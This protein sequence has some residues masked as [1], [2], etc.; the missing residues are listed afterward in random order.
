M[1]TTKIH[2]GSMPTHSLRRRIE[3]RIEAT[4]RAGRV[5]QIIL[6]LDG[7]LF[8]NAYRTKVILREAAR[9]RLGADHPLVAAISTLPLERFEFSVEDTCRGLGVE[10]EERLAMFREE[11]LTRFF[12]NNYLVHDAP[13]AGGA[14]AARAWWERGAEI[15]YLTGRHAPEMTR[16]TVQSL[17][18]AGCPYATVRTRLLMKPHWKQDDVEFK[19]RDAL[20]SIRRQGPVV[21]IV[22]NDPRILNPLV[23]AEPEALGLMIETRHPK[24]SPEL[25][26]GAARAADFTGLVP[27]GLDQARRAPESPADGR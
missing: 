25:A 8:E 9:V 20:P 26:A 3:D 11:W 17:L 23:A 24:T 12:S 27:D 6:D 21:L 5:P 1:R 10:D 19:E 18:D 7:T 2:E 4:V 16:G 14:A 15:N 13:V 22:D